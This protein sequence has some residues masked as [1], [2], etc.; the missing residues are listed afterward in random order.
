M[1]STK[2]EDK[3]SRDWKSRCYGDK[4]VDR[5]WSF[6]CFSPVDYSK[7]QKDLD[8]QLYTYLFEYLALTA[9]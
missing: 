5:N 1:Q 7:I 3:V 2:I 9:R 6:G 4:L 8:S